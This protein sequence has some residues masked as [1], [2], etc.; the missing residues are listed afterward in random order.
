MSESIQSI[1]TPAAPLPLGHYEQA[2]VHENLVY[3]SGQLPLAPSSETPPAKDIETQTKQVLE[4]LQA[5]LVAANSDKSRVLKVTLYITNLDEW[6]AINATYATFFED[7]KPARAAVPVTGLPKQCRIE[8]EA[9]AA[10]N[11]K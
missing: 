4:H 11:P 1:S 7:H 9:I 8:V 2:V 10:L 3:V 6:P 5:V